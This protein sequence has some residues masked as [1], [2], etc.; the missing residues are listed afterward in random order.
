MKGNNMNASTAHTH[1]LLRIAVAGVF[2][3]HGLMKL[4][5]LEGTAS[6]LPISYLSTVLVALA[7]TGGGLLVLVGGLGKDRMYDMATRIGAAINIPVMLGAIVMIHWGR[8]NFVPAEGF[9]MG[10]MEFQVVLLLL[11][12]YLTITGNQQEA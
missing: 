9:P 8:W 7:E 11:L 2:V 10:G 12:S 6:M 1:W 3:F 4:K 5:N